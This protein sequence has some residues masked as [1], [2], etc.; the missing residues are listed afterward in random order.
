MQ[1]F[2]QYVS[3]GPSTLYECI[4]YEFLHYI[5]CAGMQVS[6]RVVSS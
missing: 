6:L 2:T 5:W 3:A 4:V 1:M